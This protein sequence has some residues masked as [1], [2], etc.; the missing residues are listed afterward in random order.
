MPAPF[1]D[2]TQNPR[3]LSVV[4]SSWPRLAVSGSGF[5]CLGQ[6]WQFW[7]LLGCCAE[8]PSAGICLMFS[9]WL[10]SGYIFLGGRGI[11]EVKRAVL[12]PLYEG[13][14]STPVFLTV[15]LG[16]G[17][18]HQLSPR[19]SC[20]F[21][22]PSCCALW[23][24]V[25]VHGPCFSRAAGLPLLE[26]REPTAIWNSSAWDPSLVFPRY[27]L[28]QSFLYISMDSWVCTLCFGL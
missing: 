12:T 20:S 27:S 18:A 26:G 11:T 25:T 21:P 16:W 10:D 4:V 19:G 24:E 9:L 7:G 28:I 13:V 5:R 17:S 15:V 14:D 1:Q 2:P 6:S 22:C 23:K 3:V 8:C